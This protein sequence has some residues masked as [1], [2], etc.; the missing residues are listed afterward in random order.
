MDQHISQEE[1]R[2]II[3]SEMVKKTAA[4]KWFRSEFEDYPCNFINHK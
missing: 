4:L 1:I 2:C 3:I